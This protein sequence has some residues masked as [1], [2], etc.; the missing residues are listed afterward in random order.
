MKFKLFPVIL[1]AALTSVMTLFIAAH[2]QKNIPFLTANAHQFNIPVNY[3][4]YTEGNSVIKSGGPVD[5]EPA[6][7]SSVKA[8]VHIKTTIK[9]RVISEQPQNYGDLFDQM[10]GGGQQQYY[11]PPQIGSGSGVVIS[12]DGYIVTNYHVVNDA[13]QVTVTFDDRYTTQAKVVGKDPATDIAVLKVNETNLPYME[14]GNSDNV[15]LGQWVLAVGYPL[16]L[17]ATVT[18]GIVSAKGRSIGINRSQSASAIES[19]IQTDAAVNPGNSGGALVNTQGQLIGINS[20]IA[21]PTGSYAGY[22]YA[23]PSNIVR[24]AVND[25]MKYGSVQRAYMGI[26]YLDIRNATPE[27]SSALGLDK[28]DGVYVANTVANGGAAKA[29]IKKGDFITQINGESIHS[30]PELLEQVA[31]YQP[32]DNISVSYSRDNKIYQTNIQLTNSSGTTAIVRNGGAT[33]IYGAQFRTLSDDEKKKLGVDNGVMVTAIGNGLISK[34]TNMHKGFVI[35]NIND[36]PVNSVDDLQQS[37]AGSGNLQ[38]A[39]FYPGNNGMYY[40]GLN[41]GGTATSEQ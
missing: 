40:Y 29:G 3:A 15:K 10:F 30:G 23:I 28:N 36:E 32:G 35:T 19:F 26:E 7:A 27:Q 24:K 5:F 6:A 4:S 37:L 1:T 25:L 31:R 13:N 34:Q 9:G 8:V 41:N 20:A 16:T 11:I 33:T 12:P 14:F 21:S 38:I 39:G 22:S 17:D 18:A 2:Y